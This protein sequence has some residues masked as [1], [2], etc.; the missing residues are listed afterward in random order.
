MMKF[1]QRIAISE[2]EY[3]ELANKALEDGRIRKI[4]TLDVKGELKGQISATVSTEFNKYM[5]GDNVV[6]LFSSYNHISLLTDTEKPI[7][8][9][10]FFKDN[11]Y[12]LTLEER[13][14]KTLADL[15][16]FVV[17]PVL[18]LLFTIFGSPVG[19]TLTEEVV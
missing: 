14:R 9:T 1:Y 16:D 17:F 6:G 13:A 8:Q 18:Y 7:L 10:L 2:E 12:E 3:I 11:G 19:L 4:H 15:I 5:L